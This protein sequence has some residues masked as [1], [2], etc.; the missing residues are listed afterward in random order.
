LIDEMQFLDYTKEPL[1]L[2]L[3]RNPPSPKF[4][5]IIDAV[6]LWDPSLFTHS[7][8]YLAPRAP[9]ISAAS[10]PELS[11]RGLLG[12]GRLVWS[13][14][15]HPRL[16]GGTPRKYTIFGLKPDRDRLE[17]VATLFAEGMSAFPLCG[18][19]SGQLSR[20]SPVYTG[21]ER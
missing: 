10:T 13:A 4:H 15:L 7:P 9:F 2:A 18:S 17:A 6:G 20:G 11:V 3:A 1:E 16:L 14:F 12:V 21:T 19:Q 8:A 5:A